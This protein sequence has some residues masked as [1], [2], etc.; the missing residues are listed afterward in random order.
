MGFFYGG[1]NKLDYLGLHK[2]RTL[3][4]EGFDIIKMEPYED[5]L[6][7]PSGITD[8]YSK[9]DAIA[10]GFFYG[11]PNKLDY[12]GFHKK[13]TLVE[14]GFDIIKMEPYEDRLINPSG[15]TDEYSKLDATA[16]GFFNF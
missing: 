2:K 8:E 1:P 5:R 16:L 3:V 13:R 10:L 11:G 7:N 15:I 6:I 9:L 14:E 4:E 12:L